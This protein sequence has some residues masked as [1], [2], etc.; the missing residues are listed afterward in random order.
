MYTDCPRLF[1]QATILGTKIA[2]GCY[3]G[4]SCFWGRA[5]WCAAAHYICDVVSHAIIDPK[6]PLSQAADT[7]LSQANRKIVTGGVNS[8]LWYFQVGDQ[9]P[10]LHAGQ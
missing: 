4:V 9:V 2:P 7:S 6:S 3:A 8:I 10:Q 5:G 1:L